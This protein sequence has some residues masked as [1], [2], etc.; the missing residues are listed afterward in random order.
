MMCRAALQTCGDDCRNVHFKVSCSFL[1]LF[2]FFFFCFFS[3]FFS[4]RGITLSEVEEC[5]KYT[6]VVMSNEANHLEENQLIY[7]TSSNI[8]TT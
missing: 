6:S 4:G 7:T 3:F 2:F 5:Q 8:K 1:F